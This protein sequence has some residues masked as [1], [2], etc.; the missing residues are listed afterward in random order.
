[1][2][3]RIG[4]HARVLAR[5]GERRLRQRQVRVLAE[6]LLPEVRRVLTGVTV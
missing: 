6:A 1:M 4:G 5:V 3:E 2:V